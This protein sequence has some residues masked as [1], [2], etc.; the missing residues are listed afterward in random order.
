MTDEWLDAA[1]AMLR[2]SI[3]R[4]TVRQWRRRHAIRTRRWGRVTLYHAGDLA[5][6]EARTRA[7][8]RTPMRRRRAALQLAK[9]LHHSG[10]DQ[11][12]VSR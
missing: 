12:D 1:D 2:Y 10:H 4:D 8:M 9:A 6:V 3:S 11:K 7:D 5:A